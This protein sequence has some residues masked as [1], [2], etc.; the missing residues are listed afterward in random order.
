MI[1][2]VKV[3]R[4]ISQKAVEF[5]Y[6]GIVFGMTLAQFE[7]LTKQELEKRV[8]EVNDRSNRVKIIKKAEIEKYE[9][10]TVEQKKDYDTSNDA[11]FERWNEFED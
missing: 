2:G 4:T 9:N 10:M 5:S 3:I 6:K 8:Q 11:L 1:E 7:K